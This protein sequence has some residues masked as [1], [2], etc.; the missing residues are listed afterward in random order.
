M[1]NNEHCPYCKSTSVEDTNECVMTPGEIK[2]EYKC[3]ECGTEW[4]ATFVPI[5][6]AI[7]K[8]PEPLF[9]AIDLKSQRQRITATPVIATAKLA[10]T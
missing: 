4:E 3:L 1:T 9:S 6:R 5:R 2:Q 8:K 7:T 10:C